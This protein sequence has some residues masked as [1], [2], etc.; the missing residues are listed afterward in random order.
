[1]RK[2]VSTITIALIVVVGFGATADPAAAGGA[3]VMRVPFVLATFIP[4]TGEFVF[5]T[6]TLQETLRLGNDANG[7]FHLVGNWNIHAKGTGDFGNNYKINYTDIWVQN[8]AADGL[9]ATFNHP[10][11]A[12]IVGQAGAANVNLHGYVHITINNNGDV[13]SSFDDLRITCK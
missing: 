9:P 7:G 13:T 8:V 4:C 5:L 12:V 2:T 6:G 11:T 1:M 10:W 3:T